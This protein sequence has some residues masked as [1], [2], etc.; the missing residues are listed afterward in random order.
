MTA[1]QWVNHV[2]RKVESVDVMIDL[3]PNVLLVSE[4][5]MSIPAL[6]K[7]VLNTQYMFTCGKKQPNKSCVKMYNNGHTHSSI[8]TLS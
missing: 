2:Q 7:R 8:S 1:L 5:R 4:F 3:G 6:R